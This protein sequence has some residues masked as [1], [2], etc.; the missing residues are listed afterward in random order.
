MPPSDKRPPSLLFDVFVVASQ[1]GR[2][3]ER[4][5]AGSRIPPEEFAIYSVLTHEG[6]V[7][8]TEL[9]RELGMARSTLIFR[10][11]RMIDRRHA[12]RTANPADGRSSLIALTARGQRALDEVREPFREVLVAVHGKLTLPPGKVRAALADLM[13]AQNAVLEREAVRRR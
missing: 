10:V 1:T 2:L 13:A 9:A 11:N 5:L 12:R 3:V 6:A 4:A 7:T 8:P